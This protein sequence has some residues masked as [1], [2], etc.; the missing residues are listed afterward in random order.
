MAARSATVDSLALDGTSTFA[1]VV[2][3]TGRAVMGTDP[4]PVRGAH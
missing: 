3:K 4:F 2:G 1:E